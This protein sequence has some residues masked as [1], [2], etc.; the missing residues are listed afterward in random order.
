VEG[1]KEQPLLVARNLAKT[2]PSGQGRLNVLKGID[3]TLKEGETLGIIG[4]SGVGKTTL[5]HV[6]GG[7][8]RPDAGS[9]HFEN[10]NLMKMSRREMVKFRNQMIGFIFQFYHL[11]PEFS[12][13]ENIM[14]PLIIRGYSKYIARERAEQILSDMDL[15][16]RREHKPSELSGGE[17]QR[18]AIG[19]AV[20]SKPKILLADEPTGNLDAI[21]SGRITELLFSVAVREK[22]SMI[23]VTHNQNIVE[24]CHRIQ[25]LQD[26]KLHDY[27]KAGKEPA[28]EE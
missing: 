18:V 17:Q 24:N 26:G 13:V 6:V 20:I 8:D 12:A 11:M 4:Q 23:V 15:F 28:A 22:L 21:T 1:T 2:Y 9:L 3:L 5:L 7:L 14:M 19:R 16:D 25:L 27:Q 10:R